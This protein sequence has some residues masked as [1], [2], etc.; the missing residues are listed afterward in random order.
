MKTETQFHRKLRHNFTKI[1]QKTTSL[2]SLK[3]ET[4]LHRKPRQNFTENKDMNSPKRTRRQLY[5]NPRHDFTENGDITSLK[6]ETK[7]Y[8]KPRQNFTE[9][10]D[11]ASPETETWIHQNTDTRLDRN[12]DRFT[13][14]RD[15]KQTPS[16]HRLMNNQQY[17]SGTYIVVFWELFL[18][19][20][21]TPCVGYKRICTNQKNIQQFAINFSWNLFTGKRL[22]QIK[23]RPLDQHWS[24]YPWE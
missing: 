5:R 23:R 7:L 19:F 1:N 12:R 10:R 9:N 21:N 6:T 22:P 16:I 8:R 4:K 17:I 11:I 20:I 24:I 2:T 3:T 18:D 13:E 14:N 15:I